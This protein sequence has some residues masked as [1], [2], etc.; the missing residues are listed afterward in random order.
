MADIHTVEELRHR[1][2][3]GRSQYLELWASAPA[4]ESLCGLINGQ[5]GWLMYLRESGDAGFSSR[6]QDYTGPAER[7][8]DYYLDNGQH[9]R[10]PAAW[11]LRL[12]W[13]N[14]SEDGVVIGKSS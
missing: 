8:I 11:A 4:G 2:G 3:P 10:Y 1:L 14:D 13:H 6:N 5:V 9:D 7:V 12:V